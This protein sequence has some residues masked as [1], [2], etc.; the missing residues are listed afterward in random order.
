MIR[1][2]LLLAAGGV[3]I[4]A[5]AA[6]GNTP[7]HSGVEGALAHG[8]DVQG[9]YCVPGMGRQA[10]FAAR[11]RVMLE[12]APPGDVLSGGWEEADTRGYRYRIAQLEG[13]SGVPEALLH[14]T[15]IDRAGERYTC[16]WEEAR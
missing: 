1:A 6:C 3:A 9:R 12:R 15:V 4:L 10:E 5:L 14:T 13:G 11:T 7:A 16:A 2:R 8:W